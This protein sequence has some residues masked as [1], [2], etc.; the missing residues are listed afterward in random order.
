MIENINS[1]RNELRAAV[2]IWLCLWGLE[3]RRTVLERHRDSS[4]YANVDTYAMIDIMLVGLISVTL[5]IKILKD[6]IALKNLLTSSTKYL[7]LMYGLAILSLFWSSAPNYS[8]YRAFEVFITILAIFISL[9]YFSYQNL[10]KAVLIFA[11]TAL[12]IYNIGVWK[13]NILTFSF[14]RLHVDAASAAMI[15]TY[16]FAEIISVIHRESKKILVWLAI[17]SL[18]IVIL[19]TSSSSS[20]AVAFGVLFA[21]FSSRNKLLPIF[22]FLFFL[23]LIIIMNSSAAT[24]QDNIFMMFF[25]GKDYETVMTGTGRV[26]ILEY[27]WPLVNEKLWFG[28]GFAIS[29]RVMGYYTNTAHNIFLD[30]ILGIGIVG[31]IIFCLFLIMSVIENIKATNL[32]LQGSLG[33]RAAIATGLVNCLGTPFIGTFWSP[34]LLVFIAFLA[35]QNYQIIHYNFQYMAQDDELT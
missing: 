18:S 17:L 3:F 26:R 1:F 5:L 13:T 19:S 33:Y 30:I 2:P 25:P 24:L 8:G 14:T 31:M 10:E 11:V 35:L 16:C 29:T 20:I 23:F 28:N 15:F 27:Y 22:L 21:F 32:R 4:E 6:N 12:L 9:A 34:P 7:L